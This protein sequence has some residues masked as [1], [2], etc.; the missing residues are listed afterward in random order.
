[1]KLVTYNIRY[2]L[3]P[4]GV[5]D[6]GPIADAVRGADVI[7][8]QE[9][10]RN[11][12]RS[13]MADQPALLAE[14][15]PDYHWAFF[16]AFDMDAS[17]MGADGRVLNRRRQFGPMLLSKHRILEVRRHP[18]PKIATAR[19]FGME[20]G[21]LECVLDAPEGPLRVYS[22][23]LTSAS[24]REKLLQVQ[25]LIALHQNA[26]AR[27]GSWTGKA[28]EHD[29]G[30]LANFHA[31]DW[32]QGE[33]Q[34]ALPRHTILMGDFNMV[35]GSP[36]YIALTGEPDLATGHNLHWDSFAD[37]WTHARDS[38]GDEGHT[39]LPDPPDRAPAEPLR[40]DYCLLSPGL[41]DCVARAWVDRQADG[42][43]HLPYWVELSGA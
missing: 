34:P 36:E 15:L 32:A 14:L 6:Y 13:G 23:H 37:S 17:S 25:H 22:L 38:A 28:P 9:V 40:L 18:L 42:S 10:E 41:A 33:E 31:M 29:P 4:D 39:W 1:M 27:G 11:W 7:A 5:Y 2:A 26:H 20:T 21:A 3:G 19:S 35:P 12:R 30:E 8:L 16:P 24:R 43:D